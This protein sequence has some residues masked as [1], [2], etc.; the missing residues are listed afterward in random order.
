M[1]FVYLAFFLGGFAITHKVLE[2]RWP[3]PSIMFSLAIA[4]LVIAAIGVS[5]TML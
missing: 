5:T 4:Y 2:G 1:I 3:G